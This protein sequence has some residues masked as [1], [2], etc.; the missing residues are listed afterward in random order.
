MAEARN[1][2]KVLVTIDYYSEPNWDRLCKALAPAEI[3]RA[4]HT[5]DNAVKEAIKDADA[6]IMGGDISR[7]VFLTAKKIKWVHCDHAGLNKS[8]F[9]E[10]FDRK[11]ILSSSSGRSAPA[12]AEHAVYFIL[13]F[14][15]DSRL[16]EEQQRGHSWNH[17]YNG[18]NRFALYSRTVGIIGLGKT[19]TELIKRLQG[20]NVHI[21]AYTRS[22]KEIPPGVDKV[23]FKDKGD[24]FDKLLRESDILVIT[25][26]LTNE[27]YHMI[28]ERAFGLMKKTAFLV[29]MARGA[30]V[31]EKALYKAL[32]DKTIAGAG[33]DAFENEPLPEDSPLWDLPNM[34]ISPH[35]TPPV[36]NR[37]ASSLDIICE[38]IRLFREGKPLLNVLSSRDVFSKT[39]VPPQ[40]SPVRAGS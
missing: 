6:A 40:G 15:Y 13:S 26:P 21:L 23:Y 14:I 4:K 3:V 12:L 9:P 2:G 34:L 11:I 22:V 7:E 31:D 29:N 36:P 20:F 5:D 17:P 25:A 8:A 19:G 18:R 32:I 27:S 28:D 38:N 33:S 24:S 37:D 30:V 35:A 1:L 16:L 10:I 39:P